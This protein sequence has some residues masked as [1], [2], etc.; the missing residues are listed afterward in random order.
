MLLRSNSEKLASICN[1]SLPEEVLTSIRS[2]KL[3]NS[4]FCLC[5]SST[6][7]RRSDVLRANRFVLYTIT[8]SILPSFASFNIR[9][10]SGLF[11]DLPEIPRSAYISLTSK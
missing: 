4:T 7:L 5:K 10:S 3:K 11:I 1:M 8:Q 9:W 2:D 6:I